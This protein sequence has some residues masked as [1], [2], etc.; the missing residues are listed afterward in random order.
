MK[1]DSDLIDN[2][3]IRVKELSLA[4]I[5]LIKLRTTDKVIN[6]ISAIFPDL[7][8]GTLFVI[9]LFFLHLG[10]AIWLGNVF[11]K[12]Y[13]GFLLVA[14]FYLILGYVSLF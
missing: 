13:F 1:E 9:F 6:I 11:G 14:L 12:I 10:L 2:L 3:V 8:V 5:E 7:I 4:Y